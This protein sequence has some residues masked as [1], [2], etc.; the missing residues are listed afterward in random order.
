MSEVFIVAELEF[1]PGQEEQA[2]ALVAELCEQTHAKDDGCLL[3]GIHRVVGDDLRVLLIEKWRCRDDLDRH[4]ASEHVKEKR[5][6]EAGLFAGPAKVSF[7]EP[8]GF[9]LPSMA[10]I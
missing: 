5:S 8:A 7:L 3:Y 10:R 2:L 1:A 6:K 9:G 4:L